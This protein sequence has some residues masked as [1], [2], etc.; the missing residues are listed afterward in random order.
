MGRF[1]GVGDPVNVLPAFRGAPGT[2][3]KLPRP[4][5]ERTFL[6]IDLFWPSVFQRFFQLAHILISAVFRG[7]HFL[8]LVAVFQQVGLQGFVELA[9]RPLPVFQNIVGFE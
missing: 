6:I 3:L 7:P 8:T 2:S 1:Y 5:K 9:A 4:L